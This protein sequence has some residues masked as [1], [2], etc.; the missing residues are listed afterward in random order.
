MSALRSS[1]TPFVMPLEA[2]IPFIKPSYKADDVVRQFD[3]L[4]LGHITYIDM[5]TKES[6]RSS[7]T[8]TYSYAFIKVEPHDTD[9]GRSLRYKLQNRLVS[10]ILFDDNGDKSTGSNYWDIKPYLSVNQRMAGDYVISP[11]SVSSSVAPVQNAPYDE[12]VDVEMSEEDP[13]DAGEPPMWD[14]EALPERE[15]GEIL[16]EDDY[17]INTLCDSLM[18]HPLETIQ[19]TPR[20]SSSIGSS[21]SFFD[22][23]WSNPRP[24][25]AFFSEADV[26]AMS[27]DFEQL[28]REIEIVRNAPAYDMW[29]ITVPS[30]QN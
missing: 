2:F 20:P 9:A 26:N 27:A 15:E 28:Q 17:I 16:P 4:G 29:S 11:T 19:I 10:R 13:D 21:V 3:E 18:I 25:S 22:S 8:S 6:T 24:R 1:A 7:R 5:H 30:F 23:V 14:T 12:V